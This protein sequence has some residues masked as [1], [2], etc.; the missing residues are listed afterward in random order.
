[1]QSDTQRNS[2]PQPAAVAKPSLQP[3][4]SLSSLT[5]G[6]RSSLKNCSTAAEIAQTLLNCA[7]TQLSAAVTQVHFRDG[8]QSRTLVAHGPSISPELAQKFCEKWLAPLAIEVQTDTD[9]SAKSKHYKRDD[10]ILSVFSAPFLDADSELAE[11]AITI[12]LTGRPSSVDLVLACVDA[13]ASVATMKFAEL[14]ML[15]SVKTSATARSDEKPSANAVSNQQSQHNAALGKVATSS[16][17]KEFSFSLVNSIS[18]QLEAE[19][20]GFGMNTASRIR[21]L[22]I[23]GLPDFKAASPGVALM[24][25]AMEE[26]LD[27]ENLVIQQPGMVG[28]DGTQFAIHRRWAAESGGSCLCSIPLKDT[29]GVVAVISVRRSATRPFS[30]EEIGGLMQMLQPYGSALRVLEKATQPLQQQ[31]RIAAKESIHRNFGTKSVGRKAIIGAVILFF[32]WFAFGTLTYK[33]MCKAKVIADNMLQM[34]SPLN[35]RLMMV[36]VQPGQHV[37]AGQL[38]VE[39]DTTELALQLQ[40]LEREIASSE[41]DVRRAIDGRDT[42]AAALHK[43]RVGVLMT[44]AAA[45]QDRMEQ[46]RMVAPEDGTIVRA[47]LEK[48]IGQ[49]FSTGEPVLEFA[50]AGGWT[51]EIQIPDDIGTLVQPEQ[52]GS[53]A[54]A[55]F[56]SHS[57][58]FQIAH[59]EGTTQVLN[60]QNVFIARAPLAERPEWMKSGMEGTARV[61]TVSRPVWWVALHRVVDWC[62][63]SF[64]I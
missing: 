28:P 35:G 61:T 5:S 50:S 22:A 20:V 17:P 38:L 24:Q 26:C 56:S 63:L 52:S 59:V 49:V 46:A 47:D 44:Q 51:L 53:F 23:S 32:A 19:Q 21:V 16:S 27:H 31:M 62:R 30:K 25:Q 57:M 54:S 42:S 29:D 58:P 43:A 1:M 64:W 15:S 13:L 33:P 55:S 9:H 34:T 39:F 11:G 7:S 41:L 10:Q 18:N 12:M 37:K 14:A 2:N 4:V 3:A 45:I 36:N 8:I 60:A 6:L 40:S 48:R